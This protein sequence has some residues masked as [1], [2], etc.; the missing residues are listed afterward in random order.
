MY[1]YLSALTYEHHVH[2]C[3]GQK[4]PSDPPRIGVIDVSCYVGS[5]SSA[6]VHP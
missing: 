1:V 5:V 6:S 4:K 2:A 3:K